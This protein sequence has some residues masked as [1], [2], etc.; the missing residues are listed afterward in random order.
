LDNK[1][2]DEHTDLLY[3]TYYNPQPYDKLR[4]ELEI[5]HQKKNIFTWQE[6]P[7]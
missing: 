2:I 3:P 4:Y 6:V 5:Y 1:V 7:Q